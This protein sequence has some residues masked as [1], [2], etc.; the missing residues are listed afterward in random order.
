MTLCLTDEEKE[1]NDNST[2]SV[3]L[4]AGISIGNIFSKVR[5]NIK[6][7]LNHFPLVFNYFDYFEFLISSSIS[8]ILFFSNYLFISFLQQYFDF[9]FLYLALSV[10]L[11]FHLIFRHHASLI[12]ASKF[13][14]KAAIPL[15]WAFCRVLWIRSNSS[16]DGQNTDIDFSHGQTDTK[17]FP[18]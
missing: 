14:T 15:L 3:Q 9:D 18:G 12:Y 16:I 11:L 13:Q 8:V 7:E 6:Y 5:T 17:T 10:F 4:S 2:V 1:R